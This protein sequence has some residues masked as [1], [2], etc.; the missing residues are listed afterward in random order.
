MKKLSIDELPVYRA[1]PPN[2]RN[3]VLL[4]DGQDGAKNLSVGIGAYSKGQA[5]EFHVHAGEEEV[6][7]YLKGCGEMELEDGTRTALAKGDVTFVPE[8]E[9]HR[10]HN[11]GDEDFVFMFIYSPSGPERNIR[12]W[13]VL[14]D[15]QFTLENYQLI[16]RRA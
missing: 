15:A 6:M 7:I 4:V 14:K 16:S 1:A 3:N 13:N 5:S 8:G 9:S 12:K 10:L 11:A 2:E